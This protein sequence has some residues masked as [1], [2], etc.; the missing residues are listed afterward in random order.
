[1]RRPKRAKRNRKAKRL[2]RIAS[3]G[4]YP[5]GCKPAPHHRQRRRRSGFC[6][7][8]SAR[9]LAPPMRMQR[10]SDLVYPGPIFFLFQ[11]GITQ[12]VK[13][14][15]IR[16]ALRSR[17]QSPVSAGCPAPAFCVLSANYSGLP[18]AFQKNV[19]YFFCIHFIGNHPAGMSGARHPRPM[20][21]GASAPE[22]NTLG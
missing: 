19:L 1:M 20:R 3:I 8:R 11:K 22:R 9:F 17:K 14:G 10:Y 13:C 21:S 2:T 7:A 12:H 4:L 6:S 15:A 5:S 18:V 16:P